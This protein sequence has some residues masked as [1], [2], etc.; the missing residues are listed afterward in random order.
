MRKLKLRL[1]EI[2]YPLLGPGQ[3]PGDDNRGGNASDE[4]TETA[5][6]T[7]FR[8]KEHVMDFCMFSHEEETEVWRSLSSL[9][10]ML[11]EMQVTTSS[12]L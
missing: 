12:F 4:G 10:G 1:D 8:A 6:V 3:P 5:A 7:G 11:G 9:F 2:F